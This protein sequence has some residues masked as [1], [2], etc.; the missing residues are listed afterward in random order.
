M[1]DHLPVGNHLI[2]D[3]QKC[4]PPTSDLRFVLDYSSRLTKEHESS[5]STSDVSAT[6]SAASIADQVP[7]LNRIR[8]RSILPPLPLNHWGNRFTMAGTG[9]QDNCRYSFIDAC[10]DISVG[11]KTIY[12]KIAEDHH[13]ES[14]SE[15]FHFLTKTSQAANS[16]EVVEFCT[17]LDQKIKRLQDLKDL[18]PLLKQL[19]LTKKERAPWNKAI[20]ENTL[21]AVSALCLLKLISYTN[22]G[23][24]VSSTGTGTGG[25][26]D[27]SDLRKP[28]SAAELVIDG[29]EGQTNIFHNVAAGRHFRQIIVSTRG[30]T[31]SA[32]RVTG[33][34]GIAMAWPDVRHM[35]RC[36]RDYIAQTSKHSGWVGH[37][38]RFL[39]L[40]GSQMDIYQ[41]TPCVGHFLASD[42]AFSSLPFFLLGAR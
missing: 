15:F 8:F 37:R 12:S 25:V 10:K 11:I 40:S 4:L 27:P 35:L 13:F 30:E 23:T 1:T 3:I 19:E 28:Q 24:A 33:S 29:L 34:Q 20:P 22:R 2:L 7:F 26:K 32:E 9:L 14:G 41:S 42:F 36:M 21:F 5:V 16:T 17:A 38:R 18:R 39:I 6:Y 31:V